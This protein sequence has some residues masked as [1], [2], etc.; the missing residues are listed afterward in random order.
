MGV[1]P[2]RSVDGVG[3]HFHP[4]QRG[5]LAG[6]TGAREVLGQGVARGE[7]LRP[8]VAGAAEAHLPW[9]AG[10]DLD[11]VEAEVGV[12]GVAQH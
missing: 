9:N 11:H 1:G 8:A 4:A 12:V 6:G 5:G 2:L 3:G 10:G 7:P